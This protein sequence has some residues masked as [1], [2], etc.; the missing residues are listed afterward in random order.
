MPQTNIAYSGINGQPGMAFDM[1]TSNRDV[2]S[3]VAAVNI[4]FGVACELNSAGNA[5][6]LKDT[7]TTTTFTP[8]FIGVSLLD[9]LGVENT[10]T[11]F[12]VPPSSNPSTAT[13]YLAGQSV[14]FMRR[15]RIWVLTDGGGTFLRYGAI[16]VWHS[17]TGANAQGVFTYT[18][19]QTTAGAEI[20]VAPNVTVW[21]P[22]LIGGVTGPTFT[23]SFGNTFNTLVVEINL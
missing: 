1:E 3:R 20:D 2:V 11:V 15:G 22:D 9:S 4:P 13:G 6:P 5:V 16:N 14:P 8:Q 10:Y 23:D 21:N 7:G 19:T 17:S 12:P 18:A